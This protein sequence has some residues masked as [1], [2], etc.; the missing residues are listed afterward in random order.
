MTDKVA[1][2][3][4]ASAERGLG[5]ALAHLAADE[6]YHTVVAA[7]RRDSL[8]ILAKSIEDAGGTAS[9]MTV[10][11]TDEKQVGDL[12]TLVDDLK[13]SLD[14]VAYNAGN[15]FAH[16]TLGITSEYITSA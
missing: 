10:D 3:I 6:G 15:A 12:F 7:R 13:G 16:D 2:I 4:G 14:F 11:V 5:S 8:D 1:L 9:A